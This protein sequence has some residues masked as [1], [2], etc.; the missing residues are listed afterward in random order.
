[1]SQAPT[2]ISQAPTSMSQA[3]VK[4]DLSKNLSEIMILKLKKIET[5]LISTDK[6][7]KYEQDLLEFMNN[8]KSKIWKKGDPPVD[9]IILL[10]FILAEAWNLTPDENIKISNVS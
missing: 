2:S 4:P 5:L 8:N 9:N 7:N 3:P 6:L 10:K 1:M